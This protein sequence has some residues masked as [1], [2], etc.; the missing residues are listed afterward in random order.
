MYLNK[1]LLFWKDLCLH[2]QNV[3]FFFVELKTLWCQKVLMMK[4]LLINYIGGCIGS[5]YQ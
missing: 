5:F 3:F 4:A 2:H 1:I